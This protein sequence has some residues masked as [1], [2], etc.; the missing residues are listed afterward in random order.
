MATARRIEGY[1]IVSED[2]MLADANRHMP[3]GL[4]VEGDQIF[5][6]QA[7]DGVD[8]VVH[9]RHSQ[10]QQARA[11]LRKRLILTTGVKGIAP[12]PHNEKA[13]LWNPAGC[14]FEQ[15]LD[16]LGAHDPVVA[17]IGGPLAF[18]LFID[19][20]DVF[21]LSRA[22]GVRLPGGRPVFPEVPFMTSE[23]VLGEHGYEVAERRLLDKPKN[24]EVVGWR[25]R[26]AP[27]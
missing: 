3:D 16:A 26:A 22:P 14:S 7:L 23:Q 2:G 9:G 11:P 12:D 24:V 13:R 25:R 6:E 18:A 1:A 4:K 20:Y 15:A 10:E 19:R 8:V 5:F 21:W 27:A 17:V